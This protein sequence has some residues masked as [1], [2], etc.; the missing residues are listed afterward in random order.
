MTTVQPNQ[1]LPRRRR[2]IRPRMHHHAMTTI[3]IRRFVQ[4]RLDRTPRMNMPRPISIR[5]AANT[6]RTGVLGTATTNRSQSQPG[7]T[8]SQRRTPAKHPSAELLGI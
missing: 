4:R 2:T 1:G 7:R 6:T 5:T 3:R 8:A